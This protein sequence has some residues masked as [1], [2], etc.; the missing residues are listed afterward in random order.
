MDTGQVGTESQFWRTTLNDELLGLELSVLLA[1]IASWIHRRVEVVEFIDDVSFDR[2]VSLDLSIPDDRTRIAAPDGSEMHLLPI[3]Y[4][5]KQPLVNF[6]VRDQGGRPLFNF[7]AAENGGLMVATLKAMCTVI[8]PI[9]ESL[10][11]DIEMIVTGLESEAKP[12]LRRIVSPQAGSSEFQLRAAIADSKFV[13]W[14]LEQAVDNFMF[15]I[16]VSAVKGSRIVLKYEHQ[17]SGLVSKR[18]SMT[19]RFVQLLGWRP[20]EV[21][22]PVSAASCASS[23]HLEA[24]C[25]DGISITNLDV[26]ENGKQTNQQNSLQAAIDLSIVPASRR[27]FS[28]ERAHV[29]TSATSPFE[30]LTAELTLSPKMRGWLRTAY[31]AGVLTTATLYVIWKRLHYLTNHHGLTLTVSLLLGLAASVASLIVR[32]NTHGMTL[33]VMAGLRKIAGF[34]MV[35]PFVDALCLALVPSDTLQSGVIF[36]TFVVSAGSE[37]LLVIAGLLADRRARH[38]MSHKVL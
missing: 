21:R 37:F 2:H 28:G 18:H 24:V 36:W 38:T 1:N 15:V 4:L 16:A 30:S 22:L 33:L 23:Y 5:K 8:G 34:M 35:L 3:G 12:A 14:H 13:R 7:T 25:P 29:Q 17:E 32:P 31:F 6:S 27:V 19:R 11:E 10:A 26:L 9:T 20:Y